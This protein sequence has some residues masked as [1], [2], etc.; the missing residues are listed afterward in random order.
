[1]RRCVYSFRQFLPHLTQ[2]FYT[3]FLLINIK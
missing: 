3:S 1:L 2:L